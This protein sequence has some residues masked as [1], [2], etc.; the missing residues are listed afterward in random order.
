MRIAMVD[1]ASASQLSEGALPAVGGHAADDALPDALVF[2]VTSAVFT[3]GE[4]AEE[5]IL[6]VAQEVA[7]RLEVLSGVPLEH[8]VAA[9]SVVLLGMACVAATLLVVVVLR[10]R[11]PKWRGRGYRGGTHRTLLNG[12]LRGLCPP[13]PRRK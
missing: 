1:D 10:P 11:L 13:P 2:N 3:V 9:A 12:P 5:E 8:R 4:S 7:S 6:E